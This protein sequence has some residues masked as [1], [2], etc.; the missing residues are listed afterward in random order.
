M[1]FLLIPAVWLIAAAFVVILCRAVARS[2]AAPARAAG[3]SH[4]YVVAGDLVAWE[5]APL[6]AARLGGERLATHR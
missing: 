5:D 1:L 4:S 6:L 2:D 3:H